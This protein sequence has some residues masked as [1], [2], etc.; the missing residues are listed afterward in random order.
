MP[1]IEELVHRRSDLGT[2]VVHLTRAQGAGSARDA[3]ESILN[4]GVLRASSPFG[5]AEHPLRR[6]VV[7]NIATQDDL[8]SQRAV[9]FT[10]TP[11]QYLH[12][13]T[14]EIERRRFEFAPYGIALTKRVARGR[15]INPI[16]Y[17]DI[18]PGHDWLTVP[19]NQLIDEA[20]G[21]G[22]FSVAPIAQ[23]APLVEQMGNQPGGYWKEFWW[24]REW[25]AV[26]DVTLPDRFIVLAPQADHLHFRRILG[27]L[28]HSATIVDP[29]WGLE[30]IIA[31]LA[32]FRDDEVGPF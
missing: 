28:A 15:G 3:L 4:T 27:P 11:L 12:L 14:G 2:F 18:S 24:E 31:R 7:Q 21:T 25:R 10:E 29:H 20:I 8:D 17:L 23:L 13:L 9:C 26:G 16:W 5:M 32:G 1:T 6:A 22:R 30:S 19:F